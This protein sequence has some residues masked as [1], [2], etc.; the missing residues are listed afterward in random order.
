MRS[1]Q[2]DP[3]RLEFNDQMDLADELLAV[4]NKTVTLANLGISRE[5]RGLT[6]V[7][8]FAAY[9]KLLRSLAREI[10]ETTTTYRGY[11]R[12]LAP[13]IRALSLSGAVSSVKDSSKK[14]LWSQGVAAIDADLSSPASSLNTSAFPETGTFMDEW[15]LSVYCKTFGITNWGAALQSAKPLIEE[16]R[17][18]RNDVAHGDQ[19]AREV[20]RNTSIGDMQAKVA[21]WR[22]G[23]NR[24]LDLVEIQAAQSSFFKVK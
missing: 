9:E 8:L 11:R 20:G 13:G 5:T 1:L 19:T 17:Q 2:L 3:I 14:N 7:I 4:G 23:W 24:F 18:A 21:A 16:I 12:N 22:G 10:L 15:Q 6:M